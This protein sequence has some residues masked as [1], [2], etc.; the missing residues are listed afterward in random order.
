M[1]AAV[2]KAAKAE[3]RR[4]RRAKK[5][6]AAAAVVV[7]SEATQ[8]QQQEAAAAALRPEAEKA[9]K[10]TRNTRAPQAEHQKKECGEER[11]QRGVDL[12]L[13]ERAEGASVVEVR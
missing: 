7:A 6:A 12:Y 5:L 13:P 1:V 10:V 3:Q 8:E 2:A 4:E 11:E 9:K